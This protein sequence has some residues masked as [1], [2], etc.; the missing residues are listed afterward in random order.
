MYKRQIV[1]LSPNVTD[2]RV[3]ALAA[4]QNG[5]DALSLINTVMGMKIDLKTRKPFFENKVAGLSGAAVH[6]IAVRMVYQVRTVTDLP[7]IGMG[8]I[9]CA[10]DAI[11]LMMAGANAIAVGTASL[12]DPYAAYNIKN[13]IEKYMQ[14]NNIS[15][16]NQVVNA[17][18]K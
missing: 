15:D 18:H 4:E 11:E 1:K 16:I 10:E 14:E 12:I 13:G 2:I 3:M 7:I 5:A 17:A 6:P 8:G 9:M